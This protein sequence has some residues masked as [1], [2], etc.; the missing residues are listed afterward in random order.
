MIP[1]RFKRSYF[2]QQF[3]KR[4]RESQIVVGGPFKGMRYHGQAT[5]GV[6]DPKLMGVY[7]LELKPFIEDW[8]A[9][10]FRQIIDVGAAEGYYAVGCARL[11]PQAEIIAFESTKQGQSL[12]KSMVELNGLQKRI[13]VMGHCGQ[14]QLQAAMNATKQTLVI[15]DVEG[16]EGVLLNPVQIPALA[17][18]RI[19]VEIHDCYDEN[20]GDVV[21]S[22]LKETH[23]IQEVWTKRRILWDF[24]EPRQ[25]WR[26]M[27]L[28]PYLKQYANESRPGPMRWFCC[29]PRTRTA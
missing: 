5:C 21:R 10:S 25:L 2:A 28:L 1:L 22:Q 16:S 20:V 11:W 27:W 29:T 9:I 15:M 24:S 19:I 7:E 13:K 26:R 6:P 18:A 14:E 12:L 3:L 8:S 23:F 17:E 4:L